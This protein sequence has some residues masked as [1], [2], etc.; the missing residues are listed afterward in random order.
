MSI[1]RSIP[2]EQKLVKHP[3]AP[4]CHEFFL[5]G[6]ETMRE[7]MFFYEIN[8]KISFTSLR[9]YSRKYKKEKEFIPHR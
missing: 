1:Y 8:T 7:M 6:Y 4:L 3:P 2:K 9:R 5:S